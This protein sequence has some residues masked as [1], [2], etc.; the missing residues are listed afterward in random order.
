MEK[1]KPIS[2][3]KATNIEKEKRLFTIQGWILDGVP[4]RLI[5]KQIS[6][7][8]NLDVRQAQRYVKEA[9]ST[10]RKI[11]GVNLDMKRELKISELKQLKRSLT[12]Q[13]KGTPAG[14]M[15]IIRVEKEIIKL[16]GLEL[17][18]QIELQTT[19]A[20]IELKIVNGKNS[21]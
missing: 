15:A 1:N 7:T 18:Q 4:D 13:H 10:W 12:S 20:P 11:E 19:I 17:P 16:E 6:Q 8:W 14:I 5:V 9:Y 3:P 2:K 21:N